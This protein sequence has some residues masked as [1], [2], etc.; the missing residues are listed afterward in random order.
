MVHYAGII[1]TLN[2]E[3]LGITPSSFQLHDLSFVFDWTD[4]FT[5]QALLKGHK[6]LK[7]KPHRY[8][9]MEA[10]AFSFSITFL[11]RPHP[12]LRKSGDGLFESLRRE[13][14]NKK[15]VSVHRRHFGWCKPDFKH[16]QPFCGERDKKY[17]YYPDDCNVTFSEELLQA[18]FN[19]WGIEYKKNL[20]TDEISFF[21]ASD[22][23]DLG[24]D[25]TFYQSRFQVLS[26]P[27]VENPEHTVQKELSKKRRTGESPK[28]YLKDIVFER[29]GF[30]MNWDYSMLVDM[31]AQSLS[32]FSLG[33]PWSSCDRI[34]SMWRSKYGKAV[35]NAYLT[36]GIQTD[37]DMVEK[38]VRI[39]ASE[40]R[41]RV[42]TYPALC[43]R[44]FENPPNAI[45]SVLKMRNWWIKV[46]IPLF[47]TQNQVHKVENSGVSGVTEIL[48]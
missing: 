10:G 7:V 18:V 3:S 13:N 42:N 47:D 21:L 33:A 1:S 35:M 39:S 9:R 28:G 22:L 41:D 16:Y 43:Y 46:A 4:T 19:E 27:H 30:D 8:Q 37:H 48:T 14:P 20:P 44:F 26:I 17:K 40:Q 32:D 45:A 15:V 34:L 12:A 29:T 38:L 11:L 5:K 36:Q 31:Y 23:H 24:G 2:F 25:S 6:V